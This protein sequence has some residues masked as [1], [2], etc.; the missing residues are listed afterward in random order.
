MKVFLSTLKNERLSLIVQN[1]FIY[2]SIYQVKRPSV[3]KNGI[4]LSSSE[5][6][7]TNNNDRLGMKEV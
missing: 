3:I 4:K 5:Q 2:Q 1:L 7:M 6:L